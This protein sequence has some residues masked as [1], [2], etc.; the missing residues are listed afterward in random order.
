MRVMSYADVFFSTTLMFFSRFIL[1]ALF[2]SGAE[3]AMVGSPP[4][5]KIR[6]GFF[7]ESL[8]PPT[9]NAGTV[10]VQMRLRHLFLVRENNDI[11]WSDFML[12]R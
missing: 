4:V 12:R 3:S 5:S 10:D 8:L 11:N 9:I 2:A 1:F 6:V 7:L